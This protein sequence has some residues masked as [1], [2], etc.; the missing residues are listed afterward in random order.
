MIIILN[1][2]IKSEGIDLL[3]C[4]IPGILVYYLT[5]LKTEFP[6]IIINYYLSII[7]FLYGI[8]LTLI[9]GKT[10]GDVIER[11]I[12]VHRKGIVKAKIYSMLRILIKTSLIFFLSDVINYNFSN[13]IGPIMLLVPIKLE[14]KDGVYYSILNFLF[15]LKYIDIC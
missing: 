2:Q 8:L 4:F 5:D 12:I 13:I 14:T 6:S 1:K 7:Y 11:I 15:K 3:I 10:V 9:K